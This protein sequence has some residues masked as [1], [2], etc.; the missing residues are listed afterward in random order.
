MKKLLAFSLALLMLL[1]LAACGGKT[2]TPSGGDLTTPQGS[3]E[4]PTPNP[5]ESNAPADSNTPAPQGGEAW[6]DNEFTGQISNPGW[7]SLYAVSEIPDMMFTANFGAV[8]AQQAKE[9]AQALQNAGFDTDVRVNE[10]DVL[11]SFGAKNAAGYSVAIT[12]AMEKG[13]TSGE[14]LLVVQKG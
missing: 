5:T 4:D 10:A 12:L 11:Y 9:Y 2:D 14:L 8:S 7:D 3:S 13:E 6:P 1:C